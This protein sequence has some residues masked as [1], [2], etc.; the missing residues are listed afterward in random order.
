M[1]RL[2]RG[3]SLTIIPLSQGYSTHDDTNTDT[4]PAGQMLEF[5]T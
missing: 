2:N 4:E 3:Y 5:A 1:L